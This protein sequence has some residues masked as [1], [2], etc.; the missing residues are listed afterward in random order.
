MVDVLQR[1]F[2][3]GPIGFAGEASSSIFVAIR[4]G[5][6]NDPLT[7]ADGIVPYGDASVVVSAGVTLTLA[8]SELPVK[9]TKFDV[10][11]SLALGSGS[12]T[13]KFLF[14]TNLLIRSGG[15]LQ[16]LTGEK[17][18]LVPAGSLVTILPG[19]SV[20]SS[21]TVLQTFSASG[22]GASVVLPSSGPFTGGVL[23]SGEILSYNKVTFIAIASGG[24]TAGGSFL[25]GAAPSAD[26]CS[27]S[28]A[29]GVAVTAGVTLSTAD[30]NGSLDL[31]IDLIS[32][33]AGAVL[34]LGTPGSSA[35]FKF[36]NKIKLDVLGTL[37]AVFSGGGVRLPVGSLFSIN[38]GASFTSVSGTFIQIFDPITG[39][40]IGSPVS[41]PAS[42]SGP[43]FFQV[44]P[45]GTII[46]TNTRTSE[47]D[48]QGN[49]VI[50]MF[51][52]SASRRSVADHRGWRHDH[53]YLWRNDWWCVWWSDW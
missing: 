2:L 29:C 40:N 43:Q 9:V 34:E 1:S 44:S 46:V 52:F 3:S 41:L 47:D 37:A 26:I 18:L 31:N 11:G 48:P 25:G 36:S 24:F 13:F 21:V 42:L 28:V 35:G 50:F 15:T 4:S 30:L 19:G 20:S 7:W 38:N 27:S 22:V 39:G 14:A 32:V 23:A 33:A 49:F 5:A 6:F 17:R 12:A 53:R 45:S 51:L 8:R 16:D 10:F